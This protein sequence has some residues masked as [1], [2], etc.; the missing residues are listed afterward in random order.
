MLPIQ[1][2][3]FISLCCFTLETNET[4][5]SLMDRSLDC[6]ILVVVVFSVG[7]VSLINAEKLY[8]KVRAGLQEGQVSTRVSLIINI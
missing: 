5:I 1:A 7:S 4:I 6:F 3:R 2:A 8:L